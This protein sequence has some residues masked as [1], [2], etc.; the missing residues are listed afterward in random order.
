MCLY[1]LHCNSLTSWGWTRQVETCRS[2]DRL[3]VRYNFNLLVLY[4]QLFISVQGWITLES[5][6]KLELRSSG[7]LLRVWWQLLADVSGQPTDPIFKRQA[8]HTLRNNPEEH[9][10]LLLRCWSLKITRVQS[11]LYIQWTATCFDD[12]FGKLQDLCN[13]S[14]AFL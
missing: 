8:I 6:L 13:F 4:C 9:R 2:C 3:C 1:M 10:S 12:Q 5:V 14:F 7:M 11:S